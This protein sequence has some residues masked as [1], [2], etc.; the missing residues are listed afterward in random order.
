MFGHASNTCALWM[1]IIF[2]QRSFERKHGGSTLSSARVK[3]DRS[4]TFDT[5]L[6]HSRVAQQPLSRYTTLARPIK[7]YTT[8]VHPKR[9]V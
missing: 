9:D 3:L 7:F 8:L 2:G 5:T 6:R 4:S 1:Q